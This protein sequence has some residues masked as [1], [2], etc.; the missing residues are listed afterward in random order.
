M[1]RPSPGPDGPRVPADTG[2]GLG[3]LVVAVLELLRDLLERQALR[4][5]AAGELTP[6]E[7]ERLGQ[8]LLDLSRQFDQIRDAL[9]APEPTG[10]RLPVDLAGLLDERPPHRSSHRP[11]PRS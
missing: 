11:L 2:R 1:S 3:Q 7:V 9:G 4:R 6:E 5:M 10:I 8:A